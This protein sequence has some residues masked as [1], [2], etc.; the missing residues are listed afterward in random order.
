[1]SRRV[2]AFERAIFGIVYLP[3]YYFILY[4]IVFFAGVIVTAIGIVWTVITGRDVERKSQ[5]ASGA[6]ESISR[7]VTWV[8]SG[9]RS[10]KP[11][12]VP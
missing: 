7:P 11:G 10:D 5:A 12:W 8:F 2:D 9:E 3:L 6:W 1:M 4:P